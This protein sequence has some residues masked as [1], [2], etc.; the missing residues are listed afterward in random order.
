MFT[1]ILPVANKSLKVAAMHIQEESCK[2]KQHHLH[3]HSKK[4]MQ[5]IDEVSNPDRFGAE[6][7]SQ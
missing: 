6:F 3:L 4:L 5:L 2:N 7:F 1:L